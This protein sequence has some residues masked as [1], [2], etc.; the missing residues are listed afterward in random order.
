[1]MINQSK[2][3]LSQEKVI[4]RFINAIKEIDDKESQYFS[5]DY[6]HRQSIL[7]ISSYGNYMLI[8]SKKEKI[9]GK[10]I[11]FPYAIALPKS[12]SFLICSGKE[13][14][15]G[16]IDDCYIKS[17][18]DQ[19]LLKELAIVATNGDEDKEFEISNIAINAALKQLNRNV[20]KKKR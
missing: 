2:L 15:F 14:K 11:W 12:K 13:D 5:A 9:D 1:M 18:I 20:V 19:D 8:L 10:S 3:K 17:F 16:N 7:S 4:A 6:A